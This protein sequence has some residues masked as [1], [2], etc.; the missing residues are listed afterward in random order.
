MK[1]KNESWKKERCQISRSF[2]SEWLQV[3]DG[4]ERV[5]RGE[6]TKSTESLGGKLCCSLTQKAATKRHEER[7]RFGFQSTSFI[8]RLKLRS[9]VLTFPPPRVVDR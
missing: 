9:G 2:I 3:S 1:A 5:T 7:E 4:E 8:S 6:G